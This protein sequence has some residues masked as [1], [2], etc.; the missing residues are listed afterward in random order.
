MPPGHMEAQATE[1]PVF[2]DAHS[3]LLNSVIEEH[4]LGRQDVI[5]TDFLPAIEASN[6]AFRVAAVFIEDSF[7]PEQALR[8][9]LDMIAVLYGELDRTDALELVT[10]ADQL[11]S[12]P[13]TYKLILGLEG[14]EPLTGDLALLDI[15]HRLGLR[16]LTLTHARRNAAGDGCFY[17]PT[18]AGHP[19]GLTAFGVDV[20]D[21]A[22][23]LGILIDVSQL[24]IPG[25]WDVVEFGD[26]PFIASH[27]NCR[28]LHDHPRNLTDEQLAAIAAANGVVGIAS[29]S[30]F[31]GDGTPDLDDFLDHVDHAVAVAGI[32]HVGFGF[33]FFEYL[34]PYRAGWTEIDPP[35]G[36]T[37]NGIRGDSDVR[38][39]VTALAD[40]GYNDDEIA[41]LCHENFR[42]VFT[43]VLP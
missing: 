37:V 8:R 16:V 35:F 9:A 5:A 42:R 40:R 12:E 25:F 15:F 11:G 3:D 19:G 2:F 30:A 20:L 18:D 27:S 43:S 41:S 24:N 21:R 14:A 17:D 26:D 7:L 13:G 36:G 28:A 4:A 29:V 22:R 32:D 23:D 1:N 39:L 34:I 10:T 6:I 33:D 31:V 38:S